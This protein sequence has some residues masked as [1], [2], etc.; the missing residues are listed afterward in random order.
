MSAD[1]ALDRNCG[2]QQPIERIARASESFPIIIG[3]V[4]SCVNYP[5]FVDRTFESTFVHLS[6]CG[7]Y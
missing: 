5:E 7:K 1:S 3:S 6:T 4:S 2:S